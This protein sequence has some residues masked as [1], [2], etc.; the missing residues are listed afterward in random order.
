MNKTSL[1][2][3]KVFSIKAKEILFLDCELNDLT[4]EVVDGGPEC[5]IFKVNS[6]IMTAR[7]DW[8]RKKIERD[9]EK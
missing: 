6:A 4:I 8:F 3:G 5:K 9:L 7:S 1:S 2:F